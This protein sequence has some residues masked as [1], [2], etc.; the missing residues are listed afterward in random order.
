[1]FKNFY[2]PLLRELLMINYHRIIKVRL[3]EKRLQSERQGQGKGGSQRF[4]AATP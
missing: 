3:T 4:S 1:M 2:D